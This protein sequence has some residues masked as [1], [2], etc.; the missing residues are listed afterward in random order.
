MNDSGIGWGWFTIWLATHPCPK[1]AS[2]GCVFQTSA[3]ISKFSFKKGRLL[4]IFHHTLGVQS[5]TNVR[6]IFKMA[7]LGII[8]STITIKIHHLGLSFAGVTLFRDANVMWCNTA[9]R[10]HFLYWW[11]QVGSRFVCE[12]TPPPP[13]WALEAQWSW[14]ITDVNFV[15]TNA[16]K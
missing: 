13:P 16:N 10:V 2:K 14:P 11:T 4:S 12:W 6:I 8:F 7:F 3:L 5:S 1:K 15:L 9:F